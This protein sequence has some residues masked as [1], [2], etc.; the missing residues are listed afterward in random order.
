[1]NNDSIFI[2]EFKNDAKLE[3]VLKIGGSYQYDGKWE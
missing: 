2:G 1:M 3:G